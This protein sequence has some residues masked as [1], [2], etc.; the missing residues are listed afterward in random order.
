[1]AVDVV[2]IS[3]VVRHNLVDLVVVRHLMKAPVVKG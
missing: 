3:Q 1:M 2:L